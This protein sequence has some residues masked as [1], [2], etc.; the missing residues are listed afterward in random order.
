MARTKSFLAVAA[1]A[2]AVAG[3]SAG[4]ALAGE[5]TGNGR[6]KE[7]NGKS[8]CAFSGRNDGYFLP[9]TDPNYEPERVQSYGQL[10]KAG[11]KPFLPS[12]GVA[13]NPSKGAGEA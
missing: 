8:E 3:L 2:A 1:C 12:P 13:C 4:P 10:V 6:L 5:I 7:V 9:T 11:L